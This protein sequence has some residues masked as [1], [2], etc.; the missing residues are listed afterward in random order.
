MSSARSRSRFRLASLALLFAVALPI[1]LAAT[2][3]AAS[4]TY[5][6]SPSGSDSGPGTLSSP[7]RT[8]AK[9][10]ATLR[11]GDTLYVRGGTYVESIK[12][13]KISQGTATAP[14]RVANYPGERP[15]IQGLLWLQRPS[16]WTLDG[17]NVTWDS[18]NVSTDHM[19]KMIN[20]VGWTIKNSEI[21]GA[22]S[23]AGLLVAG[24]VTGEPANWTVS[25]NCIHDTYPSNN[26][27]QDQLIYANTDMTAGAGLIERNILFN[28]TNGM[29]VK[30]GGADVNVGGAVYVTMRN[31][32]IY[33]TSQNSLVSWRSHD[34]AIS[35][36][37]FDLAGTNYGN[38][39]GYQLTGANNTV[40]GNIGVNAKQFILND[41]GYTGVS[42][43]GGNQFPIDPKFDS[44]ASCAGFHP[45]N[46]A[47]SNYGRYA[48]TTPPADTTAPSVPAGLTATASTGQVNLAWTASTDN[49]G[50]TGYKVFRAGVQVATVTGTSY[51]DTSVAA[52]TTYAYGVAAYD[53]AGNTS[54]QATASAT[55]PA[56]SQPTTLFSDGFESGNL[57]A[58]TGSTGFVAQQQV[59]NSGSWAGRATSTGSS[60]YA[61]TSLAT[62]AADMSYDGQ[63]E[64]VS[65]G[66]SSTSLVRFR[67]SS[68][69]AILSILRRSDGALLYYN[70]VTGT[71]TVGPVMTAGAWHHLQV[72]V[73]V[74]GT[75]S[76][77][78]VW[79]DGASIAT[80][81]KTDSLGTTA[82]GRI[83]VGDPAS[84]KTYDF[85]YD[86]QTVVPGTIS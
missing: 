72:H 55:T 22:H 73:A 85:A 57:S 66:T 71:T 75:S 13:I 53:A 2:A 9:A 65:Q 12:S 5:Y 6:V 38:I 30:L 31:N 48:G 43:T 4:S 32:T 50:V 62:P 82:V 86:N 84:G 77:I 64:V 21:W 63:I 23:Y 69:A 56:A 15:V 10:L 49:V 39:R 46:A 28:A 52:G 16:Y 33:N 17:I 68:G 29:G 27:N 79:L 24:T 51:S 80:L 36:N 14:I 76:Q 1:G 47:A 70:E 41:A 67:T 58:W 61:Y 59:V 81:T 20:G 37:I 25:S 44:V 18:A 26:P 7:W 83:Y 45:T 3:G 78:G 42:D 54:A 34:N 35:G 74:N 19:V 8:V 60:S 11:A 40:S